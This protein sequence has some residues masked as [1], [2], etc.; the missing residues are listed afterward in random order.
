MIDNFMFGIMK[1]EKSPVGRCCEGAVHCVSPPYPWFPLTFAPM[2]L[3]PSVLT[4]ADTA[5]TRTI[6][7]FLQPAKY[8]NISQGGSQHPPL[9]VNCDDQPRPTAYSAAPDADLPNKC[10]KFRDTICK[11]G[12]CSQ[13]RKSRQLSFIFSEDCFC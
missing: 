9:H 10:S 12:K 7:Q 4:P 2:P 8:R 3:Q 13:T 5:Q 11:G 1:C 6:K